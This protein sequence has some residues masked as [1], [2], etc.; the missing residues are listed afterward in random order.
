MT[1]DS[2]AD[3]KSTLEALEQEFEQ[4]P[5]AHN[6]QISKLRGLLTEPKLALCDRVRALRLM[7]VAL[8]RSGVYRDALASLGEARGIAIA[9][10]SYR[11]LAKIQREMAVV[12]AWR[13]DD[14]QA[15][16]EL[17]QALA[18]GCLEQDTAS[19]ARNLAEFGRIEWEARRY[20]SAARL[21]RLVVTTSAKDLPRREAQ[22][23]KVTLCQSLN[24]L[25]EH[26]EVLEWVKQLRSELSQ[27]ER[28]LFLA[29]LEETRAL[30]GLG[31][32]EEAEALLKEAKTLIP[33]RDNA[34][35][36]AEYLEA[37]AEFLAAKGGPSVEESLT[38]IACAF[39]DQN[40]VVRSA[41]IRTSLAR[42]LFKQGDTARAR[43]TL[44]VALRGAITE[45]N[46]ELAERLR[47]EM[48]KSEEGR[49]IQEFADDVE[50]IAGRSSLDRHFI[51]LK[52]LGQGGF[53]MVH[54]AID[55][56]DGEEVALKRVYLSAVYGQQKRTQ[57]I[58][59]LGCEY[60]AASRLPPHPGIA[61]VR[62]I[63]IEPGGTLFIVQDYI[64]GTKLRELYEPVPQVTRLLP[65]LA[66]IADALAMLHAK[67]IVHRDL[68]P[69]NVIVRDEKPVII[70]FGI[71]YLEGSEDVLRRFGAAGYSAP[72]Q[73]RGEKVD[74]RADIYSLGRM[75]AEIWGG[76]LPGRFDILRALRSKDVGTMPRR[77]GLV[78][79][80]M[81]ADNPNE[82]LADLGA[83]AEA[84]RDCCSEFDMRNDLCVPKTSSAFV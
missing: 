55:L 16:V 81:L 50:E 8:N 35:E 40:L 38:R 84:L 80:Q 3:L 45:G 56:R 74:V 59:S 78:V 44:C 76:R 37:E 23:A 54:K 48:I 49:H 36:H 69:E 43:E 58:A 42:H 61:H 63:L 79:R 53:G 65:L 26:A 2:P 14:K 25:G 68:K 71:A 5:R 17:L 39:D 27:S 6:E 13:G 4:D 41:E 46:I 72:E 30:Y 75:I 83:I 11:E 33:P 82:R 15:A 10:Q 1:N 22:R 70:D 29:C 51:L 67:R 57:L 20:A 28:L 47:T 60:G 9:E 21:L 62:D 64:D 52:R 24:R 32:L 34:F 19:T 77:L 66:D 31:W 7:G 12:Y 18:Y 73:V